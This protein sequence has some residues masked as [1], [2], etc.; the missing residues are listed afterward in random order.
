MNEAGLGS[1][2]AVKGSHSQNRQICIWLTSP[3]VNSPRKQVP[4]VPDDD[5]HFSMRGAMDQL[6]EAV[7]DSHSAAEISLSCSYG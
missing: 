4:M 1:G 2:C 6:E 5:W 3:H 7:K